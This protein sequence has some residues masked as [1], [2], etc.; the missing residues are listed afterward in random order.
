MSCGARPAAPVTT[1]LAASRI[2]RLRL[3]GSSSP[4]TAVGLAA[5]H[6]DERLDDLLAG[7]RVQRRDRAGDAVAE[8]GPGGRRRVTTRA[9]EH[10]DQRMEGGAH[11]VG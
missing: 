1:A 6:R 11:V 10:G 5:D 3:N 2:R 4:R 8:P 9:R 7:R